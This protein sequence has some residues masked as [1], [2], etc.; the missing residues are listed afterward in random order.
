[1][2]LAT[3]APTRA[4]RVLA[5]VLLAFALVLTAMKSLQIENFQGDT[6]MFFQATES[7]AHRGIPASNL[8]AQIQVYERAKVFRR[9]PAEI[10]SD[11]LVGPPLASDNLLQLHAYFVLVPLGWIAALVPAPIVLLGAFAL[12]FAGLLYCALALLLAERVPLG[13][14]LL[15][16]AIV[17]THPAF[18]DSLLYGQ[19]YPDRLFMLAGMLLVLAATRITNRFALAG[20]AI[21]CAATTERGALVGGIVL[22]LVTLL[23]WRS[24]SD[25]WFKLLLG[26]GLV[27]FSVVV[28]HVLLVQGDNGG[29]FPRN[30]AT[31]ARLLSPQLLGD[32][33]TFV[34]VNTV[35]LGFALFERR[36]ALIAVVTM[37]PN[38]TGSIGGAEKVGFITHYHSYYFPIL[39][40]A[41]ALGFAR[42]YHL[43]SARTRARAFTALAAAALVFAAC[44]DPYAGGPTLSAARIGQSFIPAFVSNAETDFSRGG[45]ARSRLGEQL[46]AAV[47]VG[48]R[49]CAVESAM[50]FLYRGRTVTFFPV[51]VDRA[52]Y[53]VRPV[54][55]AVGG[56]Y[57]YGGMASR[58][59][60]AAV[61]RMNLLL[62]ERMRRDG[63]DVD[64]P[65]VVQGLDLA[66]IGR[67]RQEAR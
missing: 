44:I 54:I 34:F 9:T 8:F 47:P 15:F 51:G 14:A 66:V 62:T 20:A 53:V 19:F 56:T 25:R 60:V 50:S 7:V 27:A 43:A 35:L 30:T 46:S 4:H 49:V 11:P 36:A 63:F 64:H 41:A 24:C 17:V 18:G 40:W 16:G 58:Y 23:S 32:T 26:V 1:M 48:S 5:L 12:A 3:L 57:V 13:V 67:V 42:A 28:T 10:A 29:Y 38:V 33:L 61:R 59:G 65:T 52:Q 37:L 6:A 21:F 39:V 31:L 22:L 55:S 45:I 2:T